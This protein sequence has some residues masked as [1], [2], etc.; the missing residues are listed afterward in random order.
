M[1]AYDAARL[2]SGSIDIPGWSIV[3][4][5]RNVD[6]M[7]TLANNATIPCSV[8]RINPASWSAALG[9]DDGQVRTSPTRFLT[10][11]GQGSIDDNGNL[12]HEGDLV[13][14]LAL[15]VDN[16]ARVVEQAGMKLSDL[17]HLTIYV[18]DV[19][20]TLAV[21]DTVVERLRAANATPPATLVGVARLALPGMA[22]ELHAMAIA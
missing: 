19:D 9:Y 4:V 6:R 10:I 12:V 11:A 18:T 7:T 15:A 22:V 20:A 8:E 21:Y 17:A 14:Q 2:S 3:A 13:A 16:V 5:E 1:F